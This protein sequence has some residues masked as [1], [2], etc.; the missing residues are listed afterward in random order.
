MRFIGLLIWAGAAMWV[1]GCAPSAQN[2]KLTPEV[3]VEERF[4]AEGP[5]VALR[6]VDRRPQ[7][8]LGYRDTDRGVTIGI[9]GVLADQV[10]EA[11]SSALNSQGVAVSEW[12]GE[13]SKRLSVSIMS[14]EYK[15]TGGFLRHKVNLQTEWDVSGSFD[16]TKVNSQAQ[17]RS[18]EQMPFAPGKDKNERMVNSVLNRAINQVVNH[19]ELLKQLSER[20]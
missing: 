19:D 4:S 18:S 6:V 17:A 15:H 10:R 1:A 11:L 20:E 9:D 5:E 3:S 12:D 16:G 8:I 7:Q 2:V 14:F 13:A